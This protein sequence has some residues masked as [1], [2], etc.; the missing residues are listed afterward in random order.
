MGD[1]ANANLLAATTPGI[2]GRTF[3]IGRGERTSL[4][5]LLTKLSE[6]LGKPITPI[7]EPARVGDIRDSLADINQARSILGFEPKVSIYE[8]LLKVWITIDP[9]FE[10]R[11]PRGNRHGK[12]RQK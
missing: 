3:N 12:R 10:E 2:S 1:V 8:D 11:N 9:S 6:I 5:E 7:H 4:L